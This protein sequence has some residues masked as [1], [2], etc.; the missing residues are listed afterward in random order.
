MYFSDIDRVRKLYYFLRVLK[1]FTLKDIFV[2]IQ[3]FLL[4]LKMVKFFF[5]H[6]FFEHII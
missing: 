6:F 5:K 1:Y 3:I 2:S 4:H